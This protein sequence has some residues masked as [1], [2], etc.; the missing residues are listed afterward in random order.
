ML[1]SLKVDVFPAI[2][3]K[4]LAAIKPPDVL[5]I[6]RAVEGRS[7]N[8]QRLIR[9]RAVVG[10]LFTGALDELGRYGVVSD[11]VQT[12]PTDAANW[13]KHRAA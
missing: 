12:K 3:D 8:G 1:G 7:V 10:D 5:A 2:A 9:A 11:E 4:P 13:D 6:A